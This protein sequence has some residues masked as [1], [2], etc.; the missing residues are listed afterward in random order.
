MSET[1]GIARTPTVY[2]PRAKRGAQRVEK[3]MIIKEA[4]DEANL[5][6]GSREVG[7]VKSNEQDK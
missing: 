2:A 1:A 3:N 7:E 6:K 5:T 4:V